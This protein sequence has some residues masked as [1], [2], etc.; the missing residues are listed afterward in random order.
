MYESFF[1]LAQP[2]FSIAPDP[3]YLYMSRGHQ[4]AL[5]HLLY[6]LGAEGG[7]V[8]LT[9]EVGTGKTT[10]CRCL[11][12]QIPASCDVAYIFNP[13]L[14]V[15]ELLSTICSEFGIAHPADNTSVKVFVDCINAHLLDAHARGRS[16]VLIIDEAQNL[17][18]DVLEQMRLLTNLETNTKKLLQIVLLGQPELAELVAR[19]ELRQLAQRIVARYH[20]GPLSRA[21]VA[22][23][24][25]H[26]LGV[27]GAKRELI[28]SS[29]MRR[30]HALSGGVPRVV[31]LLCDRALLGAYA[32]G[33]QAVDRAT[34][35]RAAREV[36]GAHDHMR[37]RARRFAVAAALVTIAAAVVAFALYSREPAPRAAPAATARE[38]A[39][40][41]APVPAA[42][43]ERPSTH[44]T[45]LPGAIAWPDSEPLSSSRALAY[46]ALFRAWGEQD[47]SAQSCEHLPVGELHCRTLRGG[48][49]DLRALDVPAVL[50]LRDERGREFHACLV[51]LDE[52]SAT[53][54]LGTQRRRVAL[55]ALAGLW[56]GQ[57]SVA[58]RMPS[59]VPAVL[60]AGDRGPAVRWLR[61]A[62]A[63]L[64][65][66]ATHVQPADVFDDTA[67]REVKSFQLAHGLVPDGKAGL[68]T[69]MRLA[70]AA[71]ARAPRLSNAGGER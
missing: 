7:F 28:A 36:F 9:G 69:L 25:R 64:S 71:D 26:R 54:A 5:A 33:R 46:A 21:D 50:Q 15:P 27:S 57:Y 38:T 34:L 43:A 12:E 31:N 52:R 11:L 24:V 14:T 66:N 1:D 62:L 2:P 17:A 37:R 16:T 19:P 32:Q 23:Y 49:D 39:P 63:A 20:L 8:L 42:V 4:E 45:D 18:P 55:S 47:R 41:I 13:R 58:W 70:A 61:G 59:D 3:R 35:E 60:R 44:A 30:L 6:G 29:L 53:F 68:Q 65:G 67:T 51:A 48:L 40:S 10:V 56:S 22:S